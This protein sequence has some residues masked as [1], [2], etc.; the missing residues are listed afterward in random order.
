MQFSP[1]LPDNLEKAFQASLVLLRKVEVFP[2]LA[3]KTGNAGKHGPEPRFIFFADLSTRASSVM[4]KASQTSAGG[5]NGG[6]GA[7][8][9]AGEVVGAKL[10]EGG[11]S[12]KRRREREN[13]PCRRTTRP[14]ALGSRLGQKSAA[15]PGENLALA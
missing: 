12:L 14:L 15:C 13:R 8:R 7:E 1:R 6:S 11:M 3:R 5:S 10:C 4:Y 2:A 9:G